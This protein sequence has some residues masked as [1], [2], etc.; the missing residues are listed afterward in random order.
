MREL[1]H[2]HGR[3]WRGQ[4][5]VK[6]QLERMAMLVKYSPIIQSMGRA[7]DTFIEEIDV[8]FDIPDPTTAVWVGLKYSIP[9]TDVNPAANK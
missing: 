4:P 3:N 9:V 1:R 8:W 7:S 5:K 6:R 2:L